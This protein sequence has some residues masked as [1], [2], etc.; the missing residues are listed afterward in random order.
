MRRLFAILPMLAALAFGFGGSASAVVGGA[1]DTTHVLVGAAL[2]HQVQNGVSGNERCSGFLVSETKF[3][4]AAHCFD[5]SGDPVRITFDADSRDPGAAFVEVP[6][7]SVVNSPDFDIAVITLPA[8]AGH[9]DIG[10]AARLGS[11]D[12]VDVVG[13]GVQTI[14]HK[15]PTSF[16]RRMV[17]STRLAGDGKLDGLY[18]KLLADPGACL[19]DSGGPTLDASGNVV[20]ITSFSNGNPNCNG[21]TYALRLDNPGVQAFLSAQT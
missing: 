14:E 17:A 9:M 11:G 6:A 12:R 2:Q 19:G 4:T 8:Q 21:V 1:P 5:P 18:L 3:V 10:S 7:S 15:V 20:A 13:Y 16:G